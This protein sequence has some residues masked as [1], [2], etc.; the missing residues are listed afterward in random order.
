M[1]EKC[2]LTTHVLGKSYTNTLLES[3]LAILVLVLLGPAAL[4]F[5]AVIGMITNKGES[6]SSWDTDYSSTT[7]DWS[8]TSTSYE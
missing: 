4:M 6:S 8:S 2:Q 1:I 5:L 3:L 7:W